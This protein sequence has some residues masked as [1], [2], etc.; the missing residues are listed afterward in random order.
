VQAVE[1]LFS[2]PQNAEGFAVKPEREDVVEEGI[3]HDRIISTPQSAEWWEKQ[4]ESLPDQTNDV[5]LALIVFSDETHM[6]GSGRVKAH[7]VILS[8]GN[9]A[10]ALRWK[11]HGHR[12]LA[13]FP[14]TS[15][16]SGVN[17]EA[18]EKAAILHR[19][20][21]IIFEPLKSR[22]ERY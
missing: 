5:I 8:L 14:D 7:P 19:C 18:E 6:S 11:R 4:Q 15:A 2:D 3:F 16:S 1:S 22:S 20:L 17:L 9:I 21:E 13:F 10:L 12:L